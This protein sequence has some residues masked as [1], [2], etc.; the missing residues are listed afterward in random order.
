MSE[1][2]VSID[3]ISNRAN[4]L[5]TEL[6]GWQKLGGAATIDQLI[7]VLEIVG[8]LAHAVAQRSRKD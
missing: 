6:M 4:N 7:D 8:C 1:V 3:E 2:E 5:H